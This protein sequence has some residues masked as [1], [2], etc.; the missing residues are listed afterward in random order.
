VKSRN[1]TH[2]HHL[3]DTVRGANDIL[4]SNTS[5]AEAT[6]ANRITGFNSN[7]FNLGSAGQVNGTSSYDYS[8]WTFRKEPGFFDVVTWTGNGTA[9]RTISHNLGSV[10]GCI[11]VKCTSTG[12]NWGVYHRSTKAT[13]YLQL[14]T[15]NASASDSGLWN[16]VEP[17]ATNFTLGDGGTVNDNGDTYV[18]Y[19][20]AGG[21]STA[22]TARSVDFD[23][24]GDYLSVG[25]S[26]D[27]TMGT[28]DF[29]VEC[30]VYIDDVST[31]S[32]F[33]QI[34]DTSG[35]LTSSFNTIAANWEGDDNGWQIYGPNNTYTVSSSQPASNKTWIHVAYVRSSGTTKLYING[36]SVISMAD[37]TNYNGTYIAVGGSYSTGYLMGGKISNLRVVKGTAVYTS[38]FKPPTEPLT[39]ITNTKLL[40]CNNSSTT[41]ST[42]TPGTI[43]ANGDPTASSDSPFDDPAGFVFGDAGDQNV[44]KCGSY[45]GNGSDTVDINI[46]LGWEPTWLLVK[47]TVNSG[48]W[49]LVDSATHWPV[50]GNWETIRPNLPQAAY[51]ATETGIQLTPTGFKIVKNWGN[52]NTNGDTHVFVAIRRP[53]GYV[54]KPAEAGTDVFSL[55][56]GTNNTNPG[57]V[58]GFP[59]DFSLRRPYASSSSW[60]AASRLTGTNYLVTDGN[61]SQVSNSNQT[62]DFQN[63]I[64]K[65]GGDLT[66]WMSWQW[67]RNAGFD[68]VAYTGNGT[69][70][71][72]INHS[73]GTKSPEMIWI[74]RRD[75]SGNAG[76]WMVG[77]KGLDGGS[78][79]WNEYL[80][81]NKSQAEMSD[82]NPFNNVAPTTTSFQL[83]DWDRVN[84]N[85]ST[86]IAM[87]FASV[88]GISKVGSFVGSDSDQTITLGF[89]PRFLIVKAYNQAYSWLQL[90]TTRGWATSSG[91]NSKYLFLELNWAQDNVDVGYLTSTGFVAKGGSGNINDAGAS[92]IYYAHA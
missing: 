1:D 36:T 12:N 92:Y 41:G 54:G 80:V 45:I 72:S 37:T 64:G 7:G 46:D 22:A 13:H 14:N 56:T 15:T 73:L 20:F 89:Q 25:S 6:V 11:M 29:T 38:S 23:G 18:A 52:F 58:S 77:H 61:G 65:W 3:V 69:S 74:K 78:S 35:G 31:I 10:P 50:S 32:G 8:S 79:P 43:T 63:G 81:L 49:Q 83:S 62:F 48:N 85:N 59:V 33:F 5:D 26:S 86:Y 47:Q 71:H 75:T 60:Y 17:T 19:I 67:K 51:Y 66:S 53:D 40:C 34:S 21:E 68:V 27:F 57:F 39:N 4:E 91:N 9:G 24:T 88:S 42:V 84:A 16:N 44:I 82:N 30:W 2:D 90:D 55:A 28:G 87:L 76:D 70:G